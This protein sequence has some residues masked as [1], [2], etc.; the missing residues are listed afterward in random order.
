M[1]DPSDWVIDLDHRG[2]SVRNEVVAVPSANPVNYVQAINALDDAPRV[3]LHAHLF[4]PP[5][6]RPVPAGI[7]VPGS[8][9]IQPGHLRMA[10]TLVGLEVAAL[11]VDPFTARQVV[12]T[13]E[14]QTLFS[15][16]A[17]ALD[18]LAALR[19]LRE[20][21]D[22]DSDRVAAQ[23][24]SR[25]G[26]S[27]M[28]AAMRRFAD[29]IVGAD[30]ALAGIY[31]AWPFSGHQFIDPDVGRTRVRAVIGSLDDWTPPVYAQAQIR[32]IQLAGGDASIG[33]LTGAHH[34]FDRPDGVG[35]NDEALVAPGSLMSFIADDGS[36]IEPRMGEPDPAMVDGDLFRA[37]AADGYAGRGATLGGTP[38]TARWFEADMTRF[39]RDLFDL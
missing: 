8:S 28:T 15:L 39:Y 1:S 20:R 31:A 25:G 36:L 34:A 32:A 26:T 11:V 10:Q 37:E 13:A 6:S 4:V 23:G 17:S 21:D 18:V 9:G 14:N 29:P 35:R 30:V 19:V 33:I 24:T 22:I 12:S 27:V 16:A 3:E 7:V 38:E 5:V 2:D